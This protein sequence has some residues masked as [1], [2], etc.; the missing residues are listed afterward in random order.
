[1]TVPKVQ[2]VDKSRVAPTVNPSRPASRTPLLLRILSYYAPPPWMDMAK[3]PTAASNSESAP[4]AS[5][6]IAVGGGEGTR[7]ECADPLPPGSMEL[8]E[9]AGSSSSVT[10]AV[11]SGS[12]GSESEMRAIDKGNLEGRAMV[13]LAVAFSTCD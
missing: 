1:M 12:G 6:A 2:F 7:L 3:V 9:V 10:A 5:A 11:N 13:D 4:A 8:A